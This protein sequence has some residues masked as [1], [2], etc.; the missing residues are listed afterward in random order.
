MSEGAESF[1]AGREAAGVEVEQ[2]ERAA[3]TLDLYL[4]RLDA[5]FAEIVQHP[6]ADQRHD[7]AD[8]GD[9]DQHLH[10]RKAFLAATPAAAPRRREQP[11][12]GNADH[13]NPPLLN[14]QLASLTT[15]PS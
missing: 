7:H 2:V 6:R 3:E 8:D 11:L 4:G 10:Q 12:L 14:R 13:A 1:R 9:D 15:A 5:G